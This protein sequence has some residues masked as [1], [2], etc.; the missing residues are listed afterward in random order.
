M[1]VGVFQNKCRLN[2]IV[3]FDVMG[4]IYDIDIRSLTKYGTLDYRYVVIL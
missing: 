4:K 3:I 1:P 2:Y